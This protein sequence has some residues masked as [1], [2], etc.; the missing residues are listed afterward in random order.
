[1]RRRRV[2]PSR[3]KGAANPAEALTATATTKPAPATPSATASVAPAASIAKTIAR[4]SLWGPPT[5]CTRTSGLRATNAAARTGST[6]RAGAMRAT[7]RAS[8]M[9]ETAETAFRARTA[10]STGSL[11]SE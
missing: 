9:V 4:T 6:P 11:A 1:M 3:A 5:T 10:V 2:A 8:T 7:I